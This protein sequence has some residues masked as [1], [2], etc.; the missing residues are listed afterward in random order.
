MQSALQGRSMKRLMSTLGW[1]NVVGYSTVTAVA[2]ILHAWGL[3][4][5]ALLAIII[6]HFS[7]LQAEAVDGLHR[8]SEDSH[9]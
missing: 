6:S 2:V 4:G 5:L 3:V 9:Q 1:V 8:T 7:L